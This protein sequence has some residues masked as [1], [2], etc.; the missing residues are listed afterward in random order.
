MDGDD[1]HALDAGSIQYLSSIVFDVEFIFKL[2]CSP[3]AVVPP[4]ASR[5]V[6]GWR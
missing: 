3:K 5:D 2:R 4:T 6:S 1:H